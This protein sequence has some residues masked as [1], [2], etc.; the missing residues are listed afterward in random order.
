M[1]YADRRYV[2]ADNCPILMFPDIS[3]KTN[4]ILEKFLFFL[5]ISIEFTFQKNRTRY[6]VRKQQTH[7]IMLAH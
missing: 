3:M 4:D 1:F 5:I 2:H 6:L 7:E